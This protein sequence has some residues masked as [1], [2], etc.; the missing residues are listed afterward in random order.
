MP[1][2]LLELWRKRHTWNRAKGL[3]GRGS[4]KSNSYRSGPRDLKRNVRL[5]PH[6]L[7]EIHGFRSFRAFIRA[8]IRSHLW[9]SFC[10]TCLRRSTLV[11]SLVGRGWLST[12]RYQE[13]FR[14]GHKA[15]KM[16]RLDSPKPSH[17]PLCWPFKLIQTQHLGNMVQVLF[18]SSC[19]FLSGLH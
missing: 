11:V 19:F 7:I 1:T 6:M 12:D 5:L 8:S 4:F 16:P 3:R 9:F 2:E 14:P 15:K 10:S 18:N 13:E 17:A